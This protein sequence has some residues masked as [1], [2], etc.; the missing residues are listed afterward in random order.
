V[1]H[2]YAW[3]NNPARATL[4]GHACRILVVGRMASVLIETDDGRR[5]VTSRRALRRMVAL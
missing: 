1:T 3:G 4:K 2:R 5:V